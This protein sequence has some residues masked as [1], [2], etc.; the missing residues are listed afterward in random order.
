MVYLYCNYYSISRQ[1]ACTYIIFLRNCQKK[2]ANFRKIFHNGIDNG[3][4]MHY[5]ISAF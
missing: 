1:N 3:Y 2:L 5:T 4:F